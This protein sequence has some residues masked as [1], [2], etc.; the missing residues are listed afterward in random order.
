M[1]WTR[2]QQMASAIISFSKKL[3]T[4][5]KFPLWRG[6]RKIPRCPASS[7]WKKR[8]EGIKQEFCSPDFTPIFQVFML[9]YC[10]VN[11]LLIGEIFSIHNV[12]R[13]FMREKLN[14]TFG[15]GIARTMNSVQFK[16][17]SI[18]FA[19]LRYLILSEQIDIKI[20]DWKW[21]IS[22]IC[23]LFFSDRTFIPSQR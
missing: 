22:L 13:T 17:V 1:K 23:C 16:K 5:W 21:N 6:R 3:V 20:F 10:F 9:F 14:L 7:S 2:L 4:R 19:S 12:K 11:C 18:N 8:G 15:L